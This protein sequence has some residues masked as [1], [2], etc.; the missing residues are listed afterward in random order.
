MIYKKFKNK[1][2]AS[3]HYKEKA[4]DELD[5]GQGYYQ[6]QVSYHC[7]IDGEFKEI[8]IHAEIGSQKQDRGDRLYWVDGIEKV[9]FKDKDE[10]EMLARSIKTKEFEIDQANKVVLKLTQELIDLT[11]ERV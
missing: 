8:E 7:F 1:E 5:C 4:Y 9:V 10:K 3:D 6:D 11:K 2:D